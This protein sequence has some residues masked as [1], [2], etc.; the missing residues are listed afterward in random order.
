MVRCG[1]TSVVHES[2]VYHRQLDLAPEHVGHLGSLRDELVHANPHEWGHCF[3]DWPHADGRR[4]NRGS[5][6]SVLGKGSIQNSIFAELIEDSGCGA[7]D[8]GADILTHEEDRW[9]STHLF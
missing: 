9:I 7:V 1:P 4:A 8:T 2:P 5:E 3:D 6:E